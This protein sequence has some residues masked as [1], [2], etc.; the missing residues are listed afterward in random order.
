MTVPTQADLLVK[1]SDFQEMIVKIPMLPPREC[2]PNFRG[3]WTKRARAARDFRSEAMLYAF[4]ASNS[5]RPG[6]EKAELS[7][8]LVVRDSRYYRDP[9][10]MI[11]SLKPAI[12]GCVDAGIIK[13]DSDKHLLYKMPILYEID[14]ERAPLT[15]L[16]FE[17]LS[18]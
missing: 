18:E 8:T 10:N 6:Y 3:H 5:A 11:A 17:E 12:D 1:E 2:S 4:Y 14:K 13:D 16:E 7:I 9:D 15:I